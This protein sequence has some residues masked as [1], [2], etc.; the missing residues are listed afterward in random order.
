MK[1]FS[2]DKGKTI[3]TIILEKG[4]LQ[5]RLSYTIFSIVN[6]FEMKIQQLQNI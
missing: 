6:S 5:D 4:E 3:N 1:L 2:K